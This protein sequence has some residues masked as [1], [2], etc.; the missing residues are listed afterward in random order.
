MA[1]DESG[2]GFAD[3]DGRDD[4]RIDVDIAVFDGGIDRRHPDLDVVGGVDCAV[5]KGWDDADGHGTM[6]AGFAAAIDNGIGIAG[7]APGARL[8]SVRIA[9]PEGFIRNSWWRCGLEWLNRN[10][11]KIEVANWSFGDGDPMVGPCGVVGGRVVDKLHH[12]TCKAVDAGVTIVAAAGNESRDVGLVS[13]GAFPE[14]VTVSAVAETDGLPRRARGRFRAS[15]ASWTT[16]SRRSPY[17]WAVIGHGLSTTSWPARRRSS[18]P[19]ARTPPR[20]GSVTACSRR[21]SPDPSPGPRTRS[22]RACSTSPGS[23][24]PRPLRGRQRVKRATASMCGVWGNMSTGRTH[25]R[26]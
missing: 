1:F 7:I 18:R 9:D 8:W 19:S 14:V 12:L 22:P 25:S 6:V 15:R 17:S 26:R 16:T 2:A 5:G 3:V 4:R 13:P 10:A 20:R 24:P 21:P 23:E 11:K